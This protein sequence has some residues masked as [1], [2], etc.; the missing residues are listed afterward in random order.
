MALFVGEL[1]VQPVVA[2]IVLELPQLVVEDHVPGRRRRVDVDD[3]ANVPRCW[4][5]RSI[6]IT[7]VTPLPA[8][9]SSSLAGGGSGSEKSPLGDAKRTIVP[10][11]TPFTK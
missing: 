11:F 8:V 5:D 3:V 2:P 7:G 9:T 10:P 1:K 4:T 6:A